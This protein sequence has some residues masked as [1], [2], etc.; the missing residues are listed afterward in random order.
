MVFDFVLCSEVDPSQSR[1]FSLF[2]C[3]CFVFK[4]KNHDIDINANNYVFSAWLI[5]KLS[6]FITLHGLYQC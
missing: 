3:F 4:L 6:H 5:L 2:V 1:L